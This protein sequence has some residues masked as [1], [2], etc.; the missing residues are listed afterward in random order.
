MAP[1]AGLAV[2]MRI[3]VAFAACCTSTFSRVDTEIVAVALSGRVSFI[4]PLCLFN[5]LIGLLT[6][7]LRQSCLRRLCSISLCPPFVFL[8]QFRCFSLISALSFGPF[9][10]P[11]PLQPTSFNS[12][13]SSYVLLRIFPSPSPSSPSAPTLLQPC[14]IP[15]PPTRLY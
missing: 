13:L 2:H 12:T 3:A 5:S 10:S 11:E 14:F 9:F 8:K 15:C 4:L 7:C 6:F 1:V